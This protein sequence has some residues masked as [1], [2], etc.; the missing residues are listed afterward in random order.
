MFSLLGWAS[1]LMADATA[2]EPK[3]SMNVFV[4]KLTKRVVYAEADRN[5]VDILFSFMALPMGTIVRILAKQH[6]DNKFEVLGSLNNLYQSLKDFPECYFARGECKFMLLNPRGLFYDHFRTLKL[7]LDDAEPIK[8]YV[9]G[10]C[11]IAFA[12]HSPDIPFSICNKAVCDLCNRVMM[13]EPEF[14]DFTDFLIGGSF[15]VSNLPITFIV[16]DDLSVMPYTAADSIRLITEFGI[17][18]MRHIEERKLDI[19]CEQMLYLLRM[20][21]SHDSP[22]TQLVFGRKDSIQDF[23]GWCQGT[24]FDQ[25]GFSKKKTSTSSKMLLEVSFAKVNRKGTVIGT[26]MNGASSMSCLNTIFKSISNMSVGSYIKSGY[27][28]DLLLKPHF[29]QQYTSNN[30]LFPLQGT[31]YKSLYS[32]KRY[33]LK[34]PRLNEKYLRP[35]GMFMVTDDLVITPSTSYSTRDALNKLKVQLDDI[36]RYEVSIG[37][38]EGLRILDASLRSRSTLTSIIEHRLKK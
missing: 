36:E 3:I 35:S 31:E 12:N 37:F 9:C 38:E 34:N 25:C 4:D 1:R 16:T 28:K 18:D 14:L 17:T 20:A 11:W 10:T 8:F 5:F 6:V 24:T 26:L 33:K 30:Q 29:G 23:E 7:K 32:S 21:L 15:F 19:G 22:L 13:K 27:V 2:K